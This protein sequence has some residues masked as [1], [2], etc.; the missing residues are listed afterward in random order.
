MAWTQASEAL[1]DARVTPKWAKL[2]LGKQ[3][4]MRLDEDSHVLEMKN[5][6]IRGAQGPDKGERMIDTG[7]GEGARAIQG[8]PNPRALALSHPGAAPDIPRSD[9]PNDFQP[10]IRSASV[11]SGF[12]PD[13]H[14]AT[15]LLFLL[16][17]VSGPDVGGG[18]SGRHVKPLHP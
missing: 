8:L 18:F 3:V 15:A 16:R 9:I 4:G 6:T 13:A 7:F 5:L 14:V 11:P 10:V 17:S 12:S 1:D 2:L